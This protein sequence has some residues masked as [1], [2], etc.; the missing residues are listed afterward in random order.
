M[1]NLPLASQQNTA[2]MG[3]GPTV[4]RKGVLTLRLGRGT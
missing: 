2:R 3:K 4:A 1:D